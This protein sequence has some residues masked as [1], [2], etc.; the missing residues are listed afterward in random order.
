MSKRKLLGVAGIVVLVTAMSGPANAEETTD[1][2]VTWQITDVSPTD[3][4]QLYND[5]YDIARYADDTAIV[6]GTDDVADQL[7]ADG[8]SPVFNDTIYK[9][10]D[11]ISVS[12]D[13][14]YGGYHTVDAHE[15]HLN[16]VAADYPD[17]ATV[18]DIGDSWL[19][20]Q[21]DG[22]H[23]ILAICLTK[24]ADGDCE[25]SPDSAKPRFSVIAQIHA[26]EVATG[27][28]AWKWIDKLV[29]GYETDTEITELMDTTEMWV[30][31]IANPD[32]VDIVA[33]GGNSPILHRKNANDSYGSCTGVDLN[34]NSSFAW[35]DDS[36]NPCAETYQGPSAA[37]EPEVSALENWLR[38]IHPDQR[39]DAEDAPAPD[40]ARD[41]FISLHSYGEYIIVPWG[42]TDTT[43]PN[44]AKLREL[45]A[46][47]SEHNG[48]FVGTND[49]TVGYGTSGTTDDMAYGELG[50]AS[51]TFEMGGGGWGSCSGFLPE[52]SCIDSEL[53]P[54][55]EGA[56][57]VAAQSAAGPYA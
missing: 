17:L 27:E 9:D 41:V 31:P 4:A 10:L 47:M 5:G 24:K 43:A 53:W 50:V 23:D 49:D 3:L 29:E 14:Y 56:L 2:P 25:L 42:F 40:D 39:D 26:R 51:F 8:Y 44:D 54:I 11:P 36:T 7:R 38:D 33:S 55:N 37:S 6:V 22:G 1:L 16:Q 12:E 52:Y 45:G 30:V 21:G 35:G 19:K 48:Y 18:Y 13:T 32:G 34:R 15:A 46:A 20:T 28:V 57:M